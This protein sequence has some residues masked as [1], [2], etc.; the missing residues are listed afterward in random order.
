MKLL[1]DRVKA[2]EEELKFYKGESWM[3]NHERG[4]VVK[5][6]PSHVLGVP[7]RP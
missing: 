7:L 4:L 5:C 2:A 3:S 6:R 1:E